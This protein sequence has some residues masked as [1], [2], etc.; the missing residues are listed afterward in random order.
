MVGSSLIVLAVISA[1]IIVFACREPWTPEE[2]CQILR[3]VAPASSCAGRD[4]DAIAKM[5]CVFWVRCQLS[6]E[7][8]VLFN[9]LPLS[10]KGFDFLPQLKDA[11]LVMHQHRLLQYQ[12]LRRAWQSV[13]LQHYR[14]AQPANNVL[15]VGRAIEDPRRDFHQAMQPQRD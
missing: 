8:S 13:P 7:N 4:E 14:F 9:D 2:L 12:V 3:S 10:D 5:R 6:Q 15:V 11:L 1:Q